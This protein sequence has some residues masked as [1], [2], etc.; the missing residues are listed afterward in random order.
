M[1]QNI[2]KFS[3]SFIVIFYIYSEPLVYVRD[4]FQDQ[5]NTK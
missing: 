4:M 2:L 5:M 1:Q 3:D